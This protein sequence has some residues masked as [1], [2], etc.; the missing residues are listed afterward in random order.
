MT[1]KQFPKDFL[2]GTAT[3]AHQVEGN[4]VNCDLWS[5]EH[6][7]GSVFKEPSGDAIDHFHRY[8]EDIA[9]LA[10]LGF[11]SYRFSIEWARV[12]PEDGFFSVAAFDHYRRMLEICHENNLTPIVTYHHFTTPRW[13]ISQGGWANPETA[14]K[15]SRYCGRATQN[16]G[17]LIGAVCTINEI[18]IPKM[19]ANMFSKRQDAGYQYREMISQAAALFGVSPES[20][21]PFFFAGTPSGTEVLLSAHYQGATAIRSERGDLPVGLTIAMQDMQ[22]IEGGEETR[23]KLR[24]EI[25]DI[26]LEAARNDDFVGV[27]TYSRERYGPEGSL[28]PEEGVE[29]TQMGY[30]FWPEALGATLHY[31]DKVAGVP[32]MVTENGIGTEDDTRRVEY[33]RRVL[34]CVSKSLADGIDIRGY[35]AWSAFDNFEWMLGYDPK[36][37][38]INVDRTTQ[39]RTVKPSAHMLGKIARANQ[40]RLN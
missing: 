3:S 35:Y 32:L 33:Y 9:L 2:W 20:F 29:L 19:F 28:G 14:E 30:E 38:I 12:E 16:L 21:A 26:W 13:V 18:N 34:A 15:F 4:N 25:Q 17:D 23:D 5:L 24:G 27:Q 31:A 11:N 7:P 1:I 40:F 36:F 6:M 39:V 10:E 22:A 37:G 8:P